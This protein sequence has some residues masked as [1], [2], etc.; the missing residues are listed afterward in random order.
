V[1]RVCEGGGGK[2]VL[3]LPRTVRRWRWVRSE[4][5]LRLLQPLP[6]RF[7]FAG[8]HRIGAGGA[9][10]VLL[11]RCSAALSWKGGAAADAQVFAPPLRGEER[12][13]GAKNN[14]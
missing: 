9:G 14:R 5:V 4:N 12:S 11:L 13:V 2:W 7:R 6:P 8:S 10:L 1:G 3:L